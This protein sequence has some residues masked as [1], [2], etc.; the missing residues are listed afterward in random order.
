MS[1]R[2]PFQQNQKGPLQC[3]EWEALLV[4]ALDGTLRAEDT[5]VF[6]T[7]GKECPMCAEMLAQAKQGQEWMT[8]LHEEP[9]VPGDLVSKIL[10]RTSGASLPQLAVV[11]V[12]QP[13]PQP[14]VHF[15]TRRT[16]RDARM[17][18]TAAMAFFSLA[19]T[20]SMAGMRL[21]SLRMADLKPS[22]LQSTISR[23]FYGVK[24]QMVSYY[25]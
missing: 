7:H 22:A 11:G 14:M 18:M 20:L 4:D 16:F 12:A 2:N 13:I 19:L 23:Q 5:G 6:T 10:D 24:K 9:P 3:E 21:D 25:E 17:L 15:T 8:F 1:E